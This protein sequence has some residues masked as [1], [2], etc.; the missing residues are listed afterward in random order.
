MN[1]ESANP[2]HRKKGITTTEVEDHPHESSARHSKTERQSILN[3]GQ[4]L[5]D[6]ETVRNGLSK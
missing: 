6:L 5:K 4:G 3:L 1:P 2:K